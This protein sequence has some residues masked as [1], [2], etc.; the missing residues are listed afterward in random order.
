MCEQRIE[1]VYARNGIEFLKQVRV[2][3]PANNDAAPLSKAALLGKLD[4]ISP[5]FTAWA[6]S[7]ESTPASK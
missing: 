3:F 4:R 7:L 5:G 2:L 6:H 1:Q